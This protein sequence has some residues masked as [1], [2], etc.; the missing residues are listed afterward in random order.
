MS[1]QRS[2]ALARHEGRMLRRDPFPIAVLV[3]MPLVIIAFF[4]PALALALFSE[5]FVHANGSE[6]AVPGIAVTFSF[7][8][9]GFV[10]LAFFRDRGWN[11]WDRLRGAASV[12]EI[13][14][15]KLLPIGATALAQLG[16]LFG[17]GFLVFGFRITGSPAALILLCVALPIC[18]IAFGV[19]LV[20]VARTLQ[21]VNVVANVGTV[22]LA[23]LGGALVPLALLPSWA[24]A[25]A[26]LTPTYWAMRGLRSVVLERGGVGSVLLPIGVL[27][28][29]AVTSVVVALWRL[30]PAER[31]AGWA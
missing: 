4:R 16:V 30:A 27:L 10:G 6:Q 8:I 2:L 28:L 24:A 19:A 15:G 26:P 14:A 22:V 25:I 17:A 11:T 7:F 23:G 21:Q 5:G 31:S 9:V 29:F 13:V 20:A 12:N 3:V 1:R 18:P